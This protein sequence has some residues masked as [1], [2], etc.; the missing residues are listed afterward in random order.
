MQQAI[1]DYALIG[2]C[3]AAALVGRNGS[4]DW[5]CI[6]RFDSKSCFAALLGD[7]TAGYWRIAPVDPVLRIERQYRPG[8]LILETRFETEHGVL[9]LTDFMPPRTEEMDLIRI[10]RCE[11]G[12]VAFR[13]ELCI[14]F[15]YG[16]YVPWISIGQQGA[17]A[18]AGPDSLYLHSALPLRVENL[19]IAAEG[20]LLSGGSEPFVLTWY[21]SV[22]VPQRAPNPYESLDHTQEWW[23]DWSRKNR[24]Q[25]S[26]QPFIERSLITLKALTY[27]PSGGMI[28]APTTALPECIGGVRNWDYRY[29][30]LRDSAFTLSAFL[31]SGFAEEAEAWHDWLLRAVAGDPAQMHIVYGISGDRIQLHGEVE[32]T[33]LTGYR[34]SRPVRIGNKA[35]T[36]LQLDVY[37]EVMECLYLGRKFDLELDATEW[38]FQ[39]ALL[40]HLESIWKEPD[41][42]IWEIRANPRHFT[43]S[44][45]MAWVAFDR[46]VKAVENFG[47][48]GPVDHWIQIRE[49][50]RQHIE[51]LH[52]DPKLNAY[53]QFAGSQQVD[54][55]LLTLPMVG[56]I[57]AKDP[58]MVGTVNLIE[59]TLLR[60]GFVYRYQTDDGLDGLPPGEG[61]FIP[62]TLWLADV[63]L[64]QERWDEA[65]ELVERILGIANDVG[66]LSEEYDPHNRC[67]VGNFPQAFSHVALINTLI[68]LEEYGIFYSAET[69]SFLRK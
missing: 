12:R 11:Q 28:A 51:A 57:E 23:Q 62:C 47:L 55:S 58:R 10:V 4:I 7:G 61:A 69:R 56:F 35:S 38:N 40:H 34:D 17:R 63:Y 36:Q 53:V 22:R 45:V 46:G 20:E 33:W 25:G 15:D 16:S 18:L 39:K 48:D 32:L 1:E 24:A 31:A 21:P 27:S 9:V 5:L 54:G 8:T 14:R 66:L 65:M 41:A 6:P 50:I 26:W 59:K 60:D 2:D 13:M 3:Q 64:M 43:H 37:G 68:R 44:K 19:V 67:L 49:T 52:F 30:W 29:C 42:G